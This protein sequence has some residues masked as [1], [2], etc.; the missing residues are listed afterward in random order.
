M[1]IPVDV[2]HFHLSLG[3][4]LASFVKEAWQ[5]LSWRA[6]VVLAVLAALLGAG[7]WPWGGF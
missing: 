7:W 2:K 3:Q 1:N 5:G 6:L 4:R